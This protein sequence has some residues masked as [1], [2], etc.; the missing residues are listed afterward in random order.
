[1][2]QGRIWHIDKTEFSFDF[3]NTYKT[4]NLNFISSNYILMKEIRPLETMKKEK[5]RNRIIKN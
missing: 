1:M 2:Q 4:H 5:N 3:E